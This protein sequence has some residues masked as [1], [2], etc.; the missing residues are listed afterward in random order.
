MKP[1]VLLPRVRDAISEIDCLLVD[2][3]FMPSKE[4]YPTEAELSA[5][6]SELQ[7]VESELL[8]GQV[9]Q[10]NERKLAIGRIVADGWWKFRQEPLTKELMAIADDYQRKLASLGLRNASQEMP[11]DTNPEKERHGK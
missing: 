4:G 5:I 11:T 3:E 10:K 8:G 1:E 6:R 7:R 2:G 9:P